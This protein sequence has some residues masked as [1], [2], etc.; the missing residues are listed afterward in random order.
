MKSLILS[1]DDFGMNEAVSRGIALAAGRGALRSTAAMANC[2]FFEDALSDLERNG[3][4]LD[5]GIHLNLTWGLPL[6]RPSLVPS[7]VERGGAFFSR[8]NVLKRCLLHR[9]SEDEVYEEFRAQCARLALIR[10]RISH[11]DGHHHVHIYPIVRRAAKRVAREFGI[12]YVR[13]PREGLW[14]PWAWSAMRRLGMTLLR[15]SGKAYWRKCGFQTPDYFGGFALG[16]GPHF[17]DR[18]IATLGRLR[19]GVTEIMVHPG[20]AS[21]DNDDYDVERKEELDWIMSGELEAIAEKH[22]VEFT[23]FAELCDRH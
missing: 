14:S 7:L 2:S 5:V 17:R 15:S 1:A 16:G 3:I 8:G 18:W 12:R 20:F 6:T 9:L 11:L 19:E 22:A 13:A 10:G 4:R 21:E 23:S